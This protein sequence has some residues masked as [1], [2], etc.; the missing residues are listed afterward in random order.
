MSVAVGV[1]FGYGAVGT[2]RINNKVILGQEFI[3]H[4]YGGAQIASGI[5]AQVN[6]EFPHAFAA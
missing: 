5:A 4:L 3:G 1:S 2:L 6:D